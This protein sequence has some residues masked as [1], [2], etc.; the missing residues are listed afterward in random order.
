[1]TIN[2]ALISM[3]GEISLCSRDDK[4]T[5]YKCTETSPL[6]DV[7]QKSHEGV[8]PNDWVFEKFH[9]L[10]NSMVDY[11]ENLE[12]CQGEIVDACVDIYHNDLVKWLNPF[13]YKVDEAME[14]GLLIDKTEIIPRIQAG[15]YYQLDEFFQDILDCAQGMVDD[16]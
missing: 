16:D 11:Q 7:I 4:T 6:Y 2:D 3:T 10:L 1:M 14:S 9:D 15:Q 5:Y 13:Y 8:L 12:D